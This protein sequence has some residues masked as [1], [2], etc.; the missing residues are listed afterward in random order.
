MSPQEDANHVLKLLEASNFDVE[1]RFVQTTDQWHVDLLPRFTGGNI[2]RG[3]GDTFC[4]AAIHALCAP[5]PPKTD[6]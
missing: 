1:I 3:Q 6:A 5:K 2:Y 4:D